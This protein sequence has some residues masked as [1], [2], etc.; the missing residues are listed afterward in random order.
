MNCC[1]DYGNSNL[2]RACTIRKELIKQVAKVGKRMRG[3]EPLQSS[4]WRYWVR[5]VAFW[6]LVGLLGLLWW[7]LLALLLANG[8]GD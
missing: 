5:L 7:G 3:P 6:L 8:L 4:M 2:G 1:N